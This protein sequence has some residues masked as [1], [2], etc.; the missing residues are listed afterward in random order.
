MV[1]GL[2]VVVGVACFTNL[3]RLSYSAGCH[4]DTYLV[5]LQVCKAFRCGFQ[6]AT[7]TDFS[8]AA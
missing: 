3:R 8:S 1:V 7:E 5:G 2:C 6:V 4:A